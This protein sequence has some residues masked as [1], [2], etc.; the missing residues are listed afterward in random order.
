MKKVI[1]L[2][3]I[4]ITVI[5]TSN[6]QEKEPTKTFDVGF[7]LLPMASSVNGSTF[8]INTALATTA[9]FSFQK[10]YHS[11]FYSWEANSLSMINGWKFA[12]NQD[13]Y[14]IFGKSL[15]ANG[16]YCSIGWEY[17]IVNGGFVSLPFVELG[18]DW[19]SFSSSIV[20]VG[21]LIPITK[22]VWKK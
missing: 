8:S 3:V 12:K 2:I 21:V 18:T 10:S 19:S 15:S 11:V 4:L 16:G 14:V 13:C 7:L 6:A 5:G 20:S 22:S 17:C 1:V 9:G